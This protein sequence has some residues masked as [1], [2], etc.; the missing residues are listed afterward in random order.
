MTHLHVITGVVRQEVGS[1]L[2]VQGSWLITLVKVTRDATERWGGENHVGRGETQSRSL[3][4][5]PSTNQ[6]PE[7]LRNV[8]HDPGVSSFFQF[9]DMISP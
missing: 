9:L 3:E 6:N 7:N 1:V 8:P 2:G 4:D 5:I